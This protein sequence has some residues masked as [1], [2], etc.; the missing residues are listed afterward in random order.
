MV[1]FGYFF[2]VNGIRGSGL[3]ASGD[4]GAW[5]GRQRWVLQ[6]LVRDA[7]ISLG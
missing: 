5:L 6:K 2:F 1:S 7:N 3:R 4:I